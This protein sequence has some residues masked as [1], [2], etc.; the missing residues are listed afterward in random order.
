M[1]VEHSG[2]LLIS[3]KFSIFRTMSIEL[4]YL[5]FVVDYVYNQCYIILMFYAMCKRDPML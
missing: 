3:T 5:D 4:L 2:N 1:T